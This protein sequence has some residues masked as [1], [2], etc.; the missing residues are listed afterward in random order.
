MKITIL[1]QNVVTFGGKRNPN[2]NFEKFYEIFNKN[3][4]K[5]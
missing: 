2:H 3:D 1:P 4:G 5:K